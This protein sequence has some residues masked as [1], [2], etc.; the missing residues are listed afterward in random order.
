MEDCFD[1][2]FVFIW[3]TSRTPNEVCYRLFLR[4]WLTWTPGEVMDYADHLM[5]HGVRIRPLGELYDEEA[6]HEE[7]KAIIQSN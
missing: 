1:K 6:I 4:G 5:L 3:Q 7:V 2:D